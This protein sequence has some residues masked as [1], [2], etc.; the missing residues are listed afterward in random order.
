MTASDISENQHEYADSSPDSSAAFVGAVD[1]VLADA[2]TAAAVGLHEARGRDDTL[3]TAVQLAEKIVPGADCAG[4]SVVERTGSVSTVAWTDETVRVIDADASYGSWDGLRSAPVMRI[5]D[6]T[7]WEGCGPALAAANLRSGL[8]LRLRGR[9]RSF[10]V[11][12]LYARKP[13]AF[14]DRAAHIARL[15]AAHIGIAL[16][17]A[18]VQEQL[19]EAMH[20]RDVIGQATGILMG[21]LNIDAAQAFEHLVRASQQGNVKLRDIAARIVDAATP[22]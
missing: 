13:Q 22:E 4:I 16:E 21:R 12:T 1:L 14:D 5:D 8:F 10:S 6:T 20:T 15:L 3:R 11:L 2:L 18:A 9:Q 19:A 7:A 17:T